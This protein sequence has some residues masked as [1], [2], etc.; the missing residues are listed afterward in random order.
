MFLVE[1]YVVYDNNEFCG[2]M[3]ETGTNGILFEARW[4]L[5]IDLSLNS[6]SATREVYW[7]RATKYHF[8]LRGGEQ[9]GDSSLREFLAFLIEGPNEDI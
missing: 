7:R 5:E 9:R 3:H 8:G 6:N 2:E 1:Y 4:F